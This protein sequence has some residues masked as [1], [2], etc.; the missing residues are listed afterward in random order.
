MACDAPA[1]TDPRS[2]DVDFQVSGLTE[3]IAAT[4]IPSKMV[5][6]NFL[7]IFTFFDLIK[8]LWS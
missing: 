2:S 3:A 1:F 4:A 6:V 7:M 8:S 5:K